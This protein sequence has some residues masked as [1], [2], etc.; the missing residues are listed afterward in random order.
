MHVCIR[1]LLGNTR[2]NSKKRNIE[3]NTTK[4]RKFSLNFSMYLWAAKLY[5][6]LS[7]LS[8]VPRQRLEFDGSE[9]EIPLANVGPRGDIG[10]II[11]LVG[12]PYLTKVSEEHIPTKLNLALLGVLETKHTAK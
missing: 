1:T 8:H 11:R 7:H 2:S 10:T 4:I 9:V 3:M 5:S 6:S 12:F